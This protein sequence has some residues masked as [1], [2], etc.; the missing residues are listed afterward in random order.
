MLTA[1]VATAA[2][3]S[4]QTL[5]DLRKQLSEDL[6]GIHFAQSLVGLVLLSDELEL[7]GASYTVAD[8]SSTEMTVYA[9][10]FHGSTAVWGEDRPSLYVEGTLGF[11]EARQGLADLYQGTLPGL[12]TSVSSRWRTYGA[13]LGTGLEFPVTP[14]LHVTP[15]VDAG[16][17]W[18]E[19]RTLY[20]GPGAPLTA[21][22]A[23]GIAFNWDALTATY[24]CA[25]RVDWHHALGEHHELEVIGRYDV[26]WTEAFRVD[27]EAQDFVARSQ[28]ITLHAELT[29]PTGFTWREQT[30]DWQLMT[31]WRAFPEGT[32]FG[33]DNYVQL[34]GGLILNTG[35]GLPAGRAIEVKAAVMF[36]N[37]FQGWTVGA[38][39]LF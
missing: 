37:D 24:G 23:D 7:S 19:N 14:T 25:G 8:D 28:L 18:L 36:G 29:G 9:L 34:G 16:V 27:D 35:D 12:E 1:W 38:G 11:A 15:I 5:E 33:V 4:A 2:T 32:L 13:L 22:L 3:G 31:A 39:L 21:A 10:P 6:R 30:V 17:A 20:G 26:R